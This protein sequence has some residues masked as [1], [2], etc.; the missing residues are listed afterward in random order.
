MSEKQQR[1]RLS[2]RFRL[3]TL[4]LM[5]SVLGPTV[6]LLGPWVYEVIKAR[7]QSSQVTITAEQA[8]KG[9]Y[10]CEYYFTSDAWY[11]IGANVPSGYYCPVPPMIPKGADGEFAVIAPLPGPIVN[12]QY[13]DSE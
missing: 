8:P 7:I 9:E 1:R 12:H 11:L 5:M 2:V 10:Y 13:V 4:L 3:I 6:G